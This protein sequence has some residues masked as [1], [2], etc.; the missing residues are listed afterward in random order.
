M[1]RYMCVSFILLFC[2][3]VGTIIVMETQQVQETQESKEA[4]AL[5]KRIKKREASKIYY[6]KNEEYRKKKNKRDNEN[7]KRLYHTDPLFRENLKDY[8]FNRYW[9]EPEFREKAL[10]RVKAQRDAKR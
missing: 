4:I 1:T 5:K 8:L 7:H 3:A 2:C 9:N 6:H 10:A